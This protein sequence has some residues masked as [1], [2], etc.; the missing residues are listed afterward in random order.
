MKKIIYFTVFFWCASFLVACSATVKK[1][2]TPVDS[3]TSDSVSK[4]SSPPKSILLPPHKQEIIVV[5]PKWSPRPALTYKQRFSGVLEAHNRIRAKHHVPP[6]KWSDKLAK[7]SQQWANQMGRGSSCK[8]YHRPGTP[9]YGEN[10]YRSTAIVWSNGR[11]EVSPV[12]IKNVVKAWTDEERWYNYNRNSC[13]SGQQCG[14]Y[15]QAVW[16]KTTEVGCA[17]KVCNDR[18]QTWVCSYN[19]AGNYTGVRPY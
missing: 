10:L 2:S 19:P 7:Y 12:T 8:M 16:K 15:T 9:P 11:R 14:H 4:D 6:L 3:E 18:S 17:I 5:E 13:Q 1:D